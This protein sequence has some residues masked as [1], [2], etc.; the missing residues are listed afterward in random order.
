M[1]LIRH[2]RAPERKPIEVPDG[3]LQE[4]CVDYLERAMKNLENPDSASPHLVIPTFA[5][6]HGEAARKPLRS[7][8]G[9][10]NLEC[11]GAV[12]VELGRLEDREALPAMIRLLG[13]PRLRLRFRHY[14]ERH[15]KKT[16]AASGTCAVCKG[17]LNVSIDG[18]LL[19]AHLGLAG[20]IHRLGG[21]AGLAALEK[22]LAGPFG[23]RAYAYLAQRDTPDVRR[24]HPRPHPPRREH[25]AHG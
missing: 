6:W 1:N 12:A 3:K 24:L 21:E 10:S 25:R 11:V 7:L 5:L 17:G 9:S 22:L 13:E 4:F 19:T 18:G 14:C 23:S 2:V 8:L 15:P 16:Y 20:A